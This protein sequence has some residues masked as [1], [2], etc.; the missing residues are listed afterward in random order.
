MINSFVTQ[1]HTLSTHFYSQHSTK[2]QYKMFKIKGEKSKLS[3]FDGH[4]WQK[5]II[6]TEQILDQFLQKCIDEIFSFVA[7]SPSWAAFG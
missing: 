3:S 1:K 4:D 5:V 2:L 7:Q 6:I